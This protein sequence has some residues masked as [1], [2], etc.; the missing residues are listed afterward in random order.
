MEN[1]YENDWNCAEHPDAICGCNLGVGQMQIRR[2]VLCSVDNRGRLYLRAPR[3]KDVQLARR[4]VAAVQ[5]SADK[6][7]ELP[8]D[9][10]GIRETS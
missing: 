9:V 6:A 10:V 7:D 4:V 5:H 8:A 1:I 3:R 2:G